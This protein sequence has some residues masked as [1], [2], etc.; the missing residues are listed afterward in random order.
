VDAGAGFHKIG[1]AG[2]E[3]SETP[4]KPCYMQ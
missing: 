3:L 4:V 1:E 2:E